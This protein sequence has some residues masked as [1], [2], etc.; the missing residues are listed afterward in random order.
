[1]EA[2]GSGVVEIQVAPVEGS[3]ATDMKV[4][5]P[6]Q[7]LQDMAESQADTLRV[8]GETGT[9]EL[10]G[11]ALAAIA[12]EAQGGQVSLE[13]D[14]V[15]PSSLSQSQ[16]EAVGDRPVYDL[17]VTSNGQN[18][19][20]LGGGTATVT[21]PYTLQPG[22]N[23]QDIVVYYVYTRE[24][25]GGRTFLERMHSTYDPETKTIT[26]LTSHF[27]PFA[28]GSWSNP[29]GDVA[30]KAWYYEDVAFIAANA[31][32]EGVQPAAFDPEASMTRGM[33]VTVLHRMAG[34]P[35][36]SGTAMFADVPAD[37]WYADAVCWAV[38]TGIVQGMG[39]GRFAPEAPISRQDL[40]TLLFRYME[41]QGVDVTVSD[42]FA[43]ADEEQIAEYAR[44]AM[45]ALHQLGVVQGMDGD[46]AAPQA[47]ATRAQTA[48]MLHRL[49]NALGT[50]A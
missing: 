43:F 12:E 34:Q 2:G 27:S 15:D 16:Q 41:Q 26:F 13:V 29:F 28:I 1:M 24:L 5:L 45:Y 8:T 9:V 19:H 11:A 18:V 7:S 3:S 31:L 36:A 30:Q 14:R 32:M 46:N 35:E 10:N 39:D 22:E 38:Q 20:Y 49:L 33:L 40:A 21:L 17:S 25:N 37:A 50:E 4:T 42:G 44:Q 23:P 48:A 47:N 6:T